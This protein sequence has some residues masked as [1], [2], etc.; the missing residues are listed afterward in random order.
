[1][2]YLV[3]RALDFYY[4][5]VYHCYCRFNLLGGFFRSRSEVISTWGC[6]KM[7]HV[8]RSRAGSSF[9]TGQGKKCYGANPQHAWFPPHQWQHWGCW[10]S[11]VRLCY[12][13]CQPSCSPLHQDPPQG[14][15]WGFSRRKRSPVMTVETSLLPRERS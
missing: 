6:F 8:S 11:L 7:Q 5:L 9:L 4:R 15:S 10:V 13:L 12:E 3:N 1:M 14:L 2:K